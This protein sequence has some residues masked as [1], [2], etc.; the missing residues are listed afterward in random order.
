MPA[1]MVELAPEE[2]SHVV[3]TLPAQIAGIA[4]QNKIAVYDLPFKAS[5]QTL[6]TITRMCTSLCREVAYRVTVRV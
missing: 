2:Y 4:Y 3:F 5:A 6:L 1:R